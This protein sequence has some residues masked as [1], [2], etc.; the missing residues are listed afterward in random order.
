MRVGWAELPLH[1]GRAPRWLFERMVKLAR[2]ILE[3]MVMEFG[4]AEV[5]RRLA[6]PRWFQALGCLLGFDWHSSGL[7]TTTT[8]ALKE[9]LKYFGSSLGLG[10]AG[11]KGKTALETPSQIYYWAD[12]FGV[13]AEKL[14]SVSRLVAKIDST[15]VQDG[16]SLYHHVIIFDKTGKWTVVQQGMKDRW[17][18]RYHWKWETGRFVDDPHVG[19][20]AQRTEKK[21]LNLVASASKQNR[22]AI[23]SMV[24]E[25]S[26]S[27]IL[28]EIKLILPER[29]GL[30]RGVDIKPENMEKALLRLYKSK[31]KNFESLL[32]IRGVGAS[33][34]RALSLTAE[35]IYGA[36]P[37]FEDP[38]LY[39]FAH[40]GKDGTPYPVNRR[41]YDNTIMVLEKAIKKARLGS[42]EQLKALKKLYQLFS[43][44]QKTLF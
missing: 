31:V 30:Y 26:P 7:T 42:R 25:L 34:L 44:P 22:D 41:V 36:K 43:Q 38:A 35:L 27:Q 1:G 3:I 11:G 20:N 23:V 18:R 16:Y 12:K 32:L 6:D 17:A 13:D 33:A 4:T 8:G 19:I 14:I 10:I 40:G 29:Y 2:S 15:A 24:S 37:S 9:A 21:V 28:R 5:L 39:S